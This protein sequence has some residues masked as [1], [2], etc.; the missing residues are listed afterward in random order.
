[1]HELSSDIHKFRSL[2]S[3]LY[4]ASLAFVDFIGGRIVIHGHI[5][6]M[7]E[8]KDQAVEGF[9]FTPYQGRDHA[10]WI[11]GNRSAFD[12]RDRADLDIAAGFDELLDVRPR[13]GRREVTA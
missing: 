7:I 11:C 3:S 6:G 13:R 4:R 1:L 9:A 2:R 8:A 5:D 10:V 12:R